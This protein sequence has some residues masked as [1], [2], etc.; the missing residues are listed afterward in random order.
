MT[1][2]EAYLEPLRSYTVGDAQTVAAW[3]FLCHLSYFATAHKHGHHP[4]ATL[5]RLR[6][7]EAVRRPAKPGSPFCTITGPAG[8]TP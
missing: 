5:R 2:D 1:Y 4:N 7:A 8:V 3:R 6:Q